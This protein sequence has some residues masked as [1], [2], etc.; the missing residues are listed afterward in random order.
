MMEINPTTTFANSD[1]RISLIENYLAKV[2]VEGSNPFAL[3]IGVLVLGVG[4]VRRASP[5]NEQ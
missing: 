3:A 4:L 5:T 1:N 2:G